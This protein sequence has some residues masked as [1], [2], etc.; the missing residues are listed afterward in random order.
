MSDIL[1]GQSY[2]LHFDPKQARAMQ[3]YPPLGAMLAAAVLRERG[4]DVAFFD[5]MLAAS[6]AEWAAALAAHRPRVAVL[7][8][9]NFNYLSKMCLLNMRQA[10]FGMLA[11]ARQQGAI[12][13]AAG[14]DAS[15]HPEDY[16]RQGADY[17]L[18]GEG[19]ATLVELLEAL[20]AAGGR[21]APPAAA[22]I[23]GLAFA[24][25]NRPEEATRTPPRPPLTRLDDQPFPA[26]DL[27][28]V[29]RYRRLWLDHHGYFSMNM[30][31]TRGC[32][33]HCNWCAKPIWG[34]RYHARSPADV[35][36]EMGWLQARYAPDHVWF[37][38]DIMGLKPGW[39]P[40]FA[41]RIEAA[42]IDLP[43]KCLTRADLV[44]NRSD[45]AAAMRRAGAE[46]VWLGAESGSQK[47][48][49]AMEKGITVE[50]IEQAT[51]RLQGAG[52]RVGFFLQFGYPGETL[53]DIDQTLAMVRR[54]RPD[55]I[56]MSVSYPLPGTRFHDSVRDQLGRRQNWVDSADLAMI[57]QGPFTTA[58]YRQLHAV[59]H[60][61]FR[62]RRGWRQLRARLPHLSRW[63]RGDLREAAAVLYRLLTLPAAR[64]ALRRLAR[65]PQERL[66]PPAAM[67]R[68]AAAHPSPQPERPETG[69]AAGE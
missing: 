55:D 52:I 57:Y 30:A 27:I 28:D 49:D 58:F 2:Y 9:D 65:V 69:G 13:I 3:P 54:L 39:W 63:R 25:E 46:T 5:A 8:E 47:I 26:W 59:V 18:L 36:A 24:S 56:G 10:A 45:E 53:V 51:R 42:G 12:A 1:L 15:D 33:Y 20:R 37:A 41:D 32:P 11:L 43:F 64:L 61:E 14:S 6:E 67:P 44:V 31:T 50:Q 40:E 19:E 48:L 38:D 62:A 35:V 68:S 21:L 22:A 16:L 23:S 66:A 17:V 29:E 60:K 7:F 4:F 34:Q